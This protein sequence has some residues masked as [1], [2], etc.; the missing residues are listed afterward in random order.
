MRSFNR[1]TLECKAYRFQLLMQY[2]LSFNR[3]TLECKDKPIATAWIGQHAFNRTTLECKVL[4][5]IECALNRDL[6]IE[7][8]QNVKRGN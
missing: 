8:H 5:A 6:L 4:R 7:L 2:V 1:T 3:T